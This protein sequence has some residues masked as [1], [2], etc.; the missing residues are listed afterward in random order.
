MGVFHQLLHA[1]KDAL[2]MNKPAEGMGIY[3]QRQISILYPWWFWA[4]WPRMLA[5]L[6]LLLLYLSEQIWLLEGW[7]SLCTGTVCFLSTHSPPLLIFPGLAIGCCL[8]R[9]VS[10]CW[11]LCS[12]LLPLVCAHSFASLLVFLPSSQLSE[13][14][15]DPWS[16]IQDQMS[17]WAVL[18]VGVEVEGWWYWFVLERRL[19]IQF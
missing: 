7:I 12:Y 14:R 3:L 11:F 15:L 13:K 19:S 17:L 2:F 8:L 6:I 18:L 16:L 4:W 1:G 5:R 9:V 10:C